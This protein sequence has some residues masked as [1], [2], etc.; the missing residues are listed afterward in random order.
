M[1]GA[2]I[3]RALLLSA[4]SEGPRSVIPNLA[5]L[6]ASLV[7]R[8]PGP[9]MSAWLDG[10]LAEPNFPDARSTAESKAR[11]KGTV[12]RSRTT[13]K[14]REALHEFALVARG[15]ANTT[16]GNATAVALDR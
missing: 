5:E 4:G 7:T 9:E 15:L 14:M 13:K 1:Y 6:L 10:I 3:L 12:L 11:L 16:Y 2:R 8:V